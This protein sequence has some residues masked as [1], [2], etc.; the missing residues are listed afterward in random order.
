MPRR[1][2]GNSHDWTRSKLITHLQLSD[3]EFDECRD[4]LKKFLAESGLLG[5]KIMAS[6]NELQYS[7]LTTIPAKAHSDVPRA[8]I[9]GLA[10]ADGMRGLV[11]FAMKVNN[12]LKKGRYTERKR[13]RKSQ[14]SRNADPPS[15]QLPDEREADETPN[16][17]QRP[18][19]LTLHPEP[20]SSTGAQE[21][22]QTS[23]QAPLLED[24]T[25]H[26]FNMVFHGLNALTT[27]SQVLKDGA[28]Q[29]ITVQDLDF[30]RWKNIL[31]TTCWFDETRHL[32]ACSVVTI[33]EPCCFMVEDEWSWHAAISNMTNAGSHYIFWMGLLN[34]PPH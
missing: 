33:P 14:H 8:I 11:G 5:K 34:P 16:R 24:R 31:Q 1:G 27:V 10:S 18:D 15:I 30:V 21:Q 17:L 20:S 4:F 9:N 2:T 26:V 28:S 23:H 7:L 3:D 12:D 6:S 25:I 32:L 19:S 22:I 29:P 13:G